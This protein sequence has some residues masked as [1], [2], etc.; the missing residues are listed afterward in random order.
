MKLCAG[1]S[2]GVDFVPRRNT[3]LVACV[4]VIVQ[5]SIAI[6]RSRAYYVQR[7][8]AYYAQRVPASGRPAASR[9]C[10]TA[11]HH[12]CRGY[13][14]RARAYHAQRVPA[15]RC[16]KPRCRN[17]GD[18][19]AGASEFY[20]DVVIGSPSSV[21]LR[22]KKEKLLNGQTDSNQPQTHTHTNSCG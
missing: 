15:S 12:G 17:H 7:A 10:K 5:R 19:A 4:S 21:P 8:R 18:A 3:V 22:K 20:L 14:Q 11:L 13:V 2:P 16:S 6:L 9:C 1:S